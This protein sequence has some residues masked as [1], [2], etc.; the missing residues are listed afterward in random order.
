MVRI[1]VGDDAVNAGLQLVGA[2][3][4][5]EKVG[6]GHVHDAAEAL[7]QMGAVQLHGIESE[8]GE[9]GIAGGSLVAGQIARAGILARR[10]DAAKQAGA[11]RVE[12]IGR[13]G[14]GHQKRDAGVAGDVLG[15]LGEAG[16]EEGGPTGLVRAQGHEGC[17]GRTALF[18]GGQR[19][20]P[21]LADQAANG[22]CGGGAHDS[23]HDGRVGEAPCAGPVRREP[24][25]R[26]R[27]PASF[28]GQFTGRPA[29]V[30]SAAGPPGSDWNAPKEMRASGGRVLDLGENPAIP[31]AKALVCHISATRTGFTAAS[32]CAEAVAIRTVQK[33]CHAHHRPRR[34]R[35]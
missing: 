25:G 24:E 12:R 9:V 20:E 30:P 19:P 17:I 4:V 27:R 28:A 33:R 31:L 2:S 8:I 6:A 18:Q 15:V 21:G 3:P 32:G 5:G 13:A 29:P 7:H 14:G 23:L 34:R 22:G 26:W 11:R 16:D 10:H 35:S 1:H